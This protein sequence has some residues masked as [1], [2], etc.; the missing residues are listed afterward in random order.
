MDVAQKLEVLAG[1][2][3]YDASCA[4]S[5]VRRSGA[6]GLGSDAVDLIDGWQEQG[7]RLFAECSGAMANG[8]AGQPRAR[9]RTFSV[10]KKFLQLARC[11]ACHRHEPSVDYETEFATGIHPAHKMQP[12]VHG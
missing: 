9:G 6:G 12:L 11:V 10:P 3:K 7:Q 5:G 4:N 1:A 8:I 2:A